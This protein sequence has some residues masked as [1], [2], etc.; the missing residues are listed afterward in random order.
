[1]TQIVSVSAATAAYATE[2]LKP[3]ARISGSTQTQETT[4]LQTREARAADNLRHA[5]LTNVVGPPSIALFFL[6]A[7]ERNRA[8]AQTTMQQAEQAYFFGK[9]EIE[10]TRGDAERQSQDEQAEDH[11]EQQPEEEEQQAEVLAL[12]AP[13]DFS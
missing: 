11:P 13:D 8:L 12:P 9:E 4:Y 6:T 7:G 10:E 1:M 2:G 5:E 3:S